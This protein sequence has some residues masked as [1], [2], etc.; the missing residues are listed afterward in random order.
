MRLKRLGSSKLNETPLK[1]KLYL[2]FSDTV[3]LIF[4]MP[5]LLINAS[6]ITIDQMVLEWVSKVLENC[7]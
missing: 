7:C 1:H 5:P 2:P 6:P 3:I 4:L